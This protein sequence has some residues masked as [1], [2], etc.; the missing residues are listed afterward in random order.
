MKLRENA[1]KSR[2]ARYIRDKYKTG[3]ARKN[4][5][6]LVKKYYN[7]KRN[8]DLFTV[9][10]T[11]KQ[12][13]ILD[14]MKDPFIHKARVSVI[15]MFKD[16]IKKERIVTKLKK[17]LP[18][19]NDK[20]GHD[21]IVKYFGRWKLSA[22]KMRQRDKKLNDAL[23]KIET[24]DMIKAVNKINAVSLMKK[25]FSDIPKIH[26]KIF[27]QKLKNKA[28][29]TKKFDKLKNGIKNARDDLL[30]QNKD[31]LMTK[32][33]KMYVFS[34]IK[35]MFKA[36]EGHLQQKTKPKFSK[37]FFKKLYEIRRKKAQYNYEDK[38]NST[39]KAPMTKLNF[40][41][42]LVPN[43]PENLI[44]D[45][46]APIKKCI[47]SF[48]N[49]LHNK[50]TERR[51]DTM[52]V[53]KKNDKEILFSLLIRKYA[54]R[55]ILQPKKD[56]VGVMKREGLYKES[57]PI[58]QIKLFKLFRK[59][60]IK[61]LTKSL[62]EPSQL[63][64]LYYLINVTAMHKRIAKQ[65]FIRELIRKWRF[66]AFAKKIART[67]LELMY[68]NLHASYLQMADEFFGDDNV[69][70]SVIKEF[71]RFGNNVGMFTGEEPQVGEDMNK[72]YYSTVEK[73]YV[74]DK[75]Y[76]DDM[77]KSVKKTKIIKEETEEVEE[78][79]EKRTSIKPKNRNTKILNRGS[80]KDPFAKYKK[81]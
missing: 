24:R 61:E 18:E 38:I 6:K 53:L 58:N 47:P 29:D 12:Y 34:K 14:R 46:Y 27:L 32:I 52:N 8:D 68:K 79:E 39:H 55:E 21:T 77:R 23:N 59:K 26:A 37:D 62:E 4:W 80:K 15:Q 65:R 73:K 5:I 19:R 49:F 74:F 1:I 69:N 10:D 9:V 42:K 43:T 67:K 40:K 31:I 71:E 76:G 41:K 56:V 25:L 78:I 36:L 57:R 64:Q 63:Y 35:N 7:N 45:K 60:Y 33:Y 22:E 17:M 2:F 51:Q 28:K 20:N 44:E 50:L 48:V 13:V 66:A 70:P 11:M 3:E 75:G 72:K 16:K 54:K 30:I 81:K